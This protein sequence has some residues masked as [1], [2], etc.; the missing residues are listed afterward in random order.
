VT[1]ESLVEP[2]RATIRL[3]KRLEAPG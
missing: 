3:R 1:D 2:N